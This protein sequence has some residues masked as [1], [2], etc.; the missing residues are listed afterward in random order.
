[1]RLRIYD[2]AAARVCYGYFWIHILLRRE[3]CLVNHK[4]VQRLYSEDGL[5]L[6]LRR[7]RA[8]TVV[9]AFMRET[10]AI[11]VDEGI[12]GAGKSGRRVSLHRRPAFAQETLEADS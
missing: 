10:L 12:K 4:R 6:R 3:G 8:L 2:L 11:D 9:D 1:L 7:L 5:G